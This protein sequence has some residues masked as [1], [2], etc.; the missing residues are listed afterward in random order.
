MRGLFG[1]EL[2]PRTWVILPEP[3]QR[4]IAFHDLRQRDEMLAHGWL[5]FHAT[6]Q[7]HLAA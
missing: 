7:A 3:A 4:Y 5:D 6:C 2:P 1:R